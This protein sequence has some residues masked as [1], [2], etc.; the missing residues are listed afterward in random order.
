M[1]V[2]YE[3][4]VKGLQVLTERFIVRVHASKRGALTVAE[5][6]QLDNKRKT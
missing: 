6:K 5:A 1:S 3:C 4:Y 2:K